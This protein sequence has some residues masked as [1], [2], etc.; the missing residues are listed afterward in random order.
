M[1]AS[2]SLLPPFTGSLLPP[3]TPQGLSDDEERLIT[4]LSQKL[5]VQATY[6]TLRYLYYDGEQRMQ[7]LGISV[8]QVLAGVQQVVDWPRICVDRLAERASEIDGFRLPDATET[9]TEL[10]DICQENDF[11]AELPLT[12]QDCLVAGRGYMIVGSPD[13]DSD[14]P[15]VTAESPLNLALV[16]NPRNRMVTSA[17]QSYEAEGVYKA[18]LYLPDQTIYMSR[19]D[20][21]G[22]VVDNRDQHKFGL[23]PVV[24]FAN[25]S[26]TSDREG[27][28]Q[29]TKAIMATTDSTCRALLGMEIAREFYSIPHKYAL[30]P[31]ESDMVGPDGTQKTAMDMAMNRFLVFERD[32]AGQLPKVGQFNA[33][34]PAVFTKIVGNG[35]QLMSSYTGFPASYF[36][37]T[38]SANPASADA[39]RVAERPIERG[40]DRVQLQATA[41]LRQVGQ[42]LWRFTHRGEALPAAYKRLEVDWLDTSSP[43]P[44]A[45]SDAIAKQVAAGIL[46]A[47]SDVTLRRLRYTALER[48]QIAQDR[49]LAQQLEAELVSSVAARQT[50]TATGL[51]KDLEADNGTVQ[52]AAQQAVP[53]QA[54]R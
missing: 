41:P 26:R 24:R 45:D 32:E 2:V 35:A 37:E 47:T 5:T 50:R 12:I 14:V 48:R 3:A 30:G 27:R 29:I 6:V 10:A 4:G 38:N 15:L 39:I 1:T 22:W 9:D 18:V 8:P 16:W 19:D 21:S 54:G 7:N 49:D 17:Y 13:D 51:A 40:A 28:S 25:R 33:F 34:D 46:P 52:A 36:G 20:Q 31:K 23:V 43:T 42:L 11:A 44:A 53:T